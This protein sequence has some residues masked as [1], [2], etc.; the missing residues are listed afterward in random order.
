MQFNFSSFQFIQWKYGLDTR[1]CCQG[2]FE[3]Q[4]EVTINYV[5]SCWDPSRD[6]LLFLQ[7]ILNGT[8]TYKGLH[9]GSVF[10]LSRSHSILYSPFSWK[11]FFHFLPSSCFFAA[12]E[13]LQM[14]FAWSISLSSHT[15]TQY[16]HHSIPPSLLLNWNVTCLNRT[17]VV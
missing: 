9:N 13:V 16:T 17:L 2:C 7:K 10:P 11:P 14:F 4:E 15:L 5:I 6:L 12:A 8:Q 3:D 1:I